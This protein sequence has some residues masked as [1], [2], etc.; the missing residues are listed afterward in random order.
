VNFLVRRDGIEPARAWLSSPRLAF[1]RVLERVRTDLPLVRD[2]RGMPK[3]NAVPAA[4][5]DAI[6]TLIE[7]AADLTPKELEQERLAKLEELKKLSWMT[8]T[9]EQLAGR[10]PVS[11][12]AMGDLSTAG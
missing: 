3:K 11:V 6:I 10:I 1:L 5:L 9:A 8:H 4:D 7:D 2:T 12:F